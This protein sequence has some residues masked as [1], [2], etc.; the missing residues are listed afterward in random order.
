MY[1]YIFIYVHIL[2]YVYIHML[3]HIHMYTHPSAEAVKTDL[4]SWEN[5][6]QVT[7]S[8]CPPTKRRRTGERVKKYMKDIK[9]KHAARH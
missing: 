4:P 2:I 3:I 6:P 7:E 1:T 8:L 9:G 5:I